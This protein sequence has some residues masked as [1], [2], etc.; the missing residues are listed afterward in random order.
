MFS[1]IRC[2]SF[3]ERGSLD[4]KVERQDI[5]RC[6]AGGTSTAPEGTSRSRRA[7][8]AAGR[9]KAVQMLKMGKATTLA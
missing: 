3:D 9:G 6:D 1:I 8:G 7:V 5:E 4:V 2:G